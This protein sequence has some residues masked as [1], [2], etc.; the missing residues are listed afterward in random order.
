MISYHNYLAMY[1][2]ESQKIQKQL[3]EAKKGK[4]KDLIKN[5]D[6]YCIK[7]KMHIKLN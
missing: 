2:R 6:K 3:F 1:N 5:T 4:S 7:Y